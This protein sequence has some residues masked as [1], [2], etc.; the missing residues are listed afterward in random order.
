M[1]VG[2]S[3]FYCWRK[4][5]KQ[6][7]TAED[8]HLNARMKKLFANSWESLGSREMAKKL[9]EEGIR[10]GRGKTR[11]R[12]KSLG[13]IVQQRRAYKV[14]TRRDERAGVAD[15][16]LNQNFNPVGINQVWAGDITYLKTTQ[17]WM[18]LAVVMDLY[19]RRIVGWAIDKRMTT[20]LI[21]E[22][23]DR[24]VAIRQ[25]SKGLVFHSDRGSHP[26]CHHT[27]RL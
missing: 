23:I 3:A 22:A 9:N 19:S 2:K 7:I 21:C 8:L 1:K 13:L 20:S 10:I 14:T 11:R 18:Y 6:T 15:N 4:R 24:A 26:L 5:P 17:G 25:P 16:L 27:C 12:M